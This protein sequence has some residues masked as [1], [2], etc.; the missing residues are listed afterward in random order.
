MVTLV[1]SLNGRLYEKYGRAMIGSFE[2]CSSDVKLIVVFEGEQPGDLAQ[3]GR[4][5]AVIPIESDDY[6]RFHAR[7]DND[8]KA[9]GKF[10]AQVEKNGQMVTVPAISYRFDLVQYSFKIFALEKARTLMAADEP[11][12]WLDADVLCLR[13][14]S[15]ADLLPLF[16]GA[17]ELMSY[18]GRTH[19][20]PRGP[21]SECGF[22]GFNPSHPRT[23]AFLAHMKALYMTG[24]AMTLREWHD[25]WLWDEVRREFEKESVRFKDLSGP[26]AALD[27]PF[28]HTG[29]G[30]FFDHLKGPARKAS[31]RSSSADYQASNTPRV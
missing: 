2:A 1:T 8:P 4:S 18:I 17:D 23:D 21:H 3:T 6:D 16:P 22:L 14:F 5:H 31:G 19:F 10:T 26:F 11:F 13:P 7:F 25:S 24:E 12:G 15:S 27:H 28:I 29:L 9:N 20:P 30:R